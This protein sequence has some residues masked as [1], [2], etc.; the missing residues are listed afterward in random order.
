MCVC[1]PVHLPTC[2]AALTDAFG[3]AA[4]VALQLAVR[5]VAIQS[6]STWVRQGDLD[7]IADGAEVLRAPRQSATRACM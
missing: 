5:V 6:S 1:K 3:D 2:D 4:S 7:V